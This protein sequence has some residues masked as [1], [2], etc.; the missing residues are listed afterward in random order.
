ASLAKPCSPECCGGVAGS[1]TG[2]R[3]QRQEAT[4][5]DG[6]RPRPP[7]SEPQGFAPSGLNKLTSALRRLHPPR[8]PPNTLDKPHSLN[9]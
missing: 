8:A 5:T 6:L 2:L 7:N 1:F 3:R 9:T 4:P